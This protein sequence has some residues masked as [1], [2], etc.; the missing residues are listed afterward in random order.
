[1]LNRREKVERK[2]E[3]VNRM[4]IHEFVLIRIFGIAQ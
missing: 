2:M 1:M 4:R 3:S